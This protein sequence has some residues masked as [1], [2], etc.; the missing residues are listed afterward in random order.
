MLRFGIGIDN[1]NGALF[2]LIVD[3]RQILSDRTEENRI[4]ADAEKLKQYQ[5]GNTRRR[6][7]QELWTYKVK[8][9]VENAQDA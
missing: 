8:Y 2:G 4:K 5:G 1:I 3:A 7:M 6:S 9:D